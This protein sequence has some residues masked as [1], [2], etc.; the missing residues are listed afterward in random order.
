MDREIVVENRDQTSAIVSLP[1]VALATGLTAAIVHAAVVRE[2]LA[3]WW[4]YGAFFAVVAVVQAMAAIALFRAPTR[5]LLGAVAIG[6]LS[7]IALYALSRTIGTSFVG[8]HAGHAEPVG[9]IDLISKVAEAVQ[10]GVVIFMMRRS[11][12]PSRRALSLRRFVFVSLLVLAAVSAAIPGAPAHVKNP[13]STIQILAADQMADLPTPHDMPSE[14]PSA[15]PTEEPV[16]SEEP[17]PPCTPHATAGDAEGIATSAVLY[18]HDG[19]LWLAAPPDGSVRRLTADNGDCWAIHAT[20]RDADTIT[21]ATDSAVYDLELKSGNLRRLLPVGGGVAGLA[22]SRDGKTL[23]I[24]DFATELK[25]YSPTTGATT[26]VRNFGETMG[27]CGDMSDEIAVSWSPDGRALIVVNTAIEGESSMFVVDRAGKNLVAPRMGT[28]ARW[29]PDSNRI[30]YR[31]FDAPMRWY[32]LDVDTARSVGVGMRTGTHHAAVSPDG[33]FVAYSDDADNPALYLY[34]VARD[35]ERVLTHGYGA[36]IWLSSDEIAVTKTIPCDENCMMEHGWMQDDETAAFDL[37]GHLTRKLSM[38]ST[39]DA[40]VFLEPHEAPPPATAPATPTPSPSPS[41]TETADPLPLS[42][43]SPPA[44]P[45]PSS[46]P[47]S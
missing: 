33:R 34:D 25:L 19:D 30:L 5:K 31:G 47:T 4:G 28:L 11:Y 45:E 20:F 41:P 27:R 6:N 1:F 16:V 14:E 21:F 2:H 26:S 23:A 13:T 42:T 24:L 18:S 8:P 44:S 3:H 38:K 35:V 22:W 40:S 7:L 10:F 29:M 37:Q 32:M 15:P 36:P 46:S 43:A 9:L 17:P 12:Q 39:M